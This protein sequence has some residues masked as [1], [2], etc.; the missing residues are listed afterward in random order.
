M[1]EYRS[2]PPAAEACLCRVYPSSQKGGTLIAEDVWDLAT[3]E[4]RLET[5]AAYQPADR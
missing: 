1:T 4:Q 2:P 3:H 5:P